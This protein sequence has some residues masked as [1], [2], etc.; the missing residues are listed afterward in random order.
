MNSLN[1]AR[2]IT[3]IDELRDDDDQ[4]EYENFQLEINLKNKEIQRRKEELEDLLKDLEDQSEVAL[5]RRISKIEK[6]DEQNFAEIPD[7]LR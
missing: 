7:S 1:R 6:E 4:V 5:S 3:N 2:I